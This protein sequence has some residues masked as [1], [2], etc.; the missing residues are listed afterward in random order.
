MRKALVTI[1]CLAV[2]AAVVVGLLQAGDSN[3][4]GSDV[5]RPLSLAQVSRPVA[6][7]PAELAALQRRV[8]DLQPGGA[9]AL[10]A[11]LRA[12]R[13]RPVVVNLWA[14]WC[15]PCIFELPI[16]QRVALRYGA[17]VAFLGVNSGDN[18]GDARKLSARFPMPYPSIEDPRQAMTGRYG[19]VGLPATAF[20]D[21]RG[22]RVVHQG[23]FTSEAQLAAAIERYALAR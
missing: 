1:A 18:R 16:F 8:N 4:G 14:S 7:A 19:A 9:R 15:D 5:L 2:G 23:R 3:S 6:G 11:Q 21:A 13:G 20:Y 17:R 10:D 12:L 22:K